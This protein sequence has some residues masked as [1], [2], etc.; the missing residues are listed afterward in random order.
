MISQFVYYISVRVS[1]TKSFHKFRLFRV[2]K[3]RYENRSLSIV[4][5]YDAKRSDVV[6]GF[7]Y[8]PVKSLLVRTSVLDSSMFLRL[9]HVPTRTNIVAFVSNEGN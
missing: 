2:L 7:L 9:V 6:L 1:V 4:F 8:P 3:I 5:L